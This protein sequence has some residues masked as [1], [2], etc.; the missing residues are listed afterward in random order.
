V[1]REKKEG[2]RKERERKKRGREKVC[3]TRVHQ[4][5]FKTFLISQVP[6]PLLLTGFKGALIEWLV[7]LWHHHE[8]YHGAHLEDLRPVDC[9]H[10]VWRYDHLEL[11]VRVQC[12]NE[13]G[14]FLMDGVHDAD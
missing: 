7:L 1:V 14:T 10:G 11:Q 9:S 4:K 8:V 6:V 5:R 12:L 3:F 13:Y 2:R